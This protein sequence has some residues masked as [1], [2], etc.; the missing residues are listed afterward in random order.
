MAGHYMRSQAAY[1]AERIDQRR[2]KAREDGI[3]LL[4]EILALNDAVDIR[5][6]M[7]ERHAL[8]SHVYDTLHVRDYAIVSN[9]R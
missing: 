2:K 9:A 6:S 7:R 4:T 8:A 1:D 3:A 5:M